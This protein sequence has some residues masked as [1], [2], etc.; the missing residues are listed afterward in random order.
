M[1]MAAFTLTPLP[2]LLAG[3]LLLTRAAQNRAT[4]WIVGIASLLLLFKALAVTLW[5][6][7]TFAHP[8]GALDPLAAMIAVPMTIMPSSIW[9][10]IVMGTSIALSRR[11]QHP[12]EE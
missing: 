12:K 11:L 3:I 10:V 5:A 1:F 6:V 4:A 7:Q 2:V 8:K 9:G